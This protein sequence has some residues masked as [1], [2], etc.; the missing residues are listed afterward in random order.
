M[1]D[2]RHAITA[3]SVLVRIAMP[4]G[5]QPPSFRVFVTA[6]VFGATTASASRSGTE[7]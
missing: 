6:P 3:V 1:T 5:M 7:T 2:F 4:T